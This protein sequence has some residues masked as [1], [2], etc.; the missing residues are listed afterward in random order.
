MHPVCVCVCVGEIQSH[1][2]V[3]PAVTVYM[4][5]NVTGALVLFL[6]TVSVLTPV[7]GRE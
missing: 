6:H 7:S 3:V 1:L 5:A 2:P 4:L